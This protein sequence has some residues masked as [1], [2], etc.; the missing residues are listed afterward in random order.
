MRTLIVNTSDSG[1]GAAIAAMRLHE[2]LLGLG[3][4]SHVGVDLRT[5]DSPRVHTLAPGNRI[6]DRALT[7]ATWRMGLGSIGTTGSFRL[8]RQP[9]FAEADVVNYH[10]LHSGRFNF[11]ALPGLARR[12]PAILTLHDMWA[13]T[14][15]CVYSFDCERWKAGCGRCPYPETYPAIR[16]DATRLELAMKKRVYRRSDL[17]VVAIS[18]WIER[19]TRESVLRDQP[20]HHIPNGVDL[21]VFSPANRERTRKELGLKSDKRILLCGAVDLGDRRKGADLLEAALRKLPDEIKRT[22][23]LLVMGQADPTTFADV[24]IESVRLGFVAGER[25][26]AGVFSA[27]DVF[28]F[29]TRADNLPLMIEESLAC[30]TPSV[31]FD[32]GGVSDLVRA[33]ETGLLAPPESVSEF[34]AALHRLLTEDAWRESLRRRCREI[35]EKEFSIELQARRYLALFESVRR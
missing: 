9:C 31:S 22:T 16:R 32:V 5:S 10:L 14:G 26:R 29:P 1:G 24:G 6:L 25:E 8:H 34:A 30:G 18:R 4:D 12:K 15:H 2:G 28:A 21:H 17:H 3:V 23:T 35:A 11:L 20:V 7:A 19:Q 13:F 33:G 27:A